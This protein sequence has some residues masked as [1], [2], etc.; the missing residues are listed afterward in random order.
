ML[1]GVAAAGRSP[2]ATSK[3]W[4]SG[5]GLSPSS[6]LSC[7]QQ[8][9]GGDGIECKGPGGPEGSVPRGGAPWLSRE[10]PPGRKAWEPLQGSFWG[11][12]SLGVPSPL[13]GG[14][15]W[16]DPTAFTALLTGR[17]LTPDALFILTRE[18]A[19]P[20]C[21]LHLTEAESP[22]KDAVLC[23]QALDWCRRDLRFPRVLCGPFC[24]P[25]EVAGS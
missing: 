8:R 5:Q 4:S 3:P 9:T 22:W 1:P 15:P 6:E 13:P 12:L 19:L 21:P 25:R 10:P 23:W 20:S 11:P 24:P 16:L 18:A 17:P 14:L 7:S 2:W